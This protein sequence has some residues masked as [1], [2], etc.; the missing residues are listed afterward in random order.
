[1]LQTVS[2]DTATAAQFWLLN[3][4]NISTEFVIQKFLKRFALLARISNQLT[5][6]GYNHWEFHQRLTLDAIYCTSR[7]LN[8]QIVH[9]DMKVCFDV[10]KSFHWYRLTFD[11]ICNPKQ[12]AV[13]RFKTNNCFNICNHDNLPCMSVSES[14]SPSYSIWNSEDIVRFS[15]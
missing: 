4:V 15:G 6:M 3:K 8:K 10:R 12:K 13:C 11:V 2:T 14:L 9:G 5:C 7:E 1:M